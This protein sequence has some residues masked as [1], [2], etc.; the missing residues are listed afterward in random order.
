MCVKKKVKDG[1]DEW[2][3]SIRMNILEVTRPIPDPT[4]TTTAAVPVIAYAVFCQK[5]LDDESFPFPCAAGVVEK[6]QNVLVV[7]MGWRR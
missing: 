6:P 4:R 3:G 5:A 7:V 2:W 1:S